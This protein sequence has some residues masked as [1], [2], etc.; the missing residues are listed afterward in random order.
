MKRRKKE[1]EVKMKARKYG[2]HMCLCINFYD[3]ALL[4]QILARTKFLS[5]T[6]QKQGHWHLF[7][8]DNY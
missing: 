4:S 6:S 3:L 7:S 5:K 2:I 8:T 1:V